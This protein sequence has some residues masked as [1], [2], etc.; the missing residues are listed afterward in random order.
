MAM[1]RPAD[2]GEAPRYAA[3]KTILAVVVLA[4]FVAGLVVSA[5]FAHVS[6]SVAAPGSIPTPAPAID[7]TRPAALPAS[8]TG[9]LPDL[10][11]VAERALKVSANISST[12]V[13]QP[14]R[15]PISRF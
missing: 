15:D 2:P 11:T 9:G 10:S 14:P 1:W 3:L 12:R 7:Q 6:P 8:S 5:R 4:G 13:V